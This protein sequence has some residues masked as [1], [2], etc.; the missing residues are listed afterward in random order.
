M[1]IEA[2]NLVPIEDGRYL[3]DL[4]WV[5]HYQVAITFV[6]TPKAPQPPEVRE[7]ARRRAIELYADG[8]RTFQAVADQLNIERVPPHRALMWTKATVRN[9][10]KNR[11]GS[12][13]TP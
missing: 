10:I 3:V 13:A 9:V 1:R 7:A 2:T 11:R 5:T 8:A 4:A 12:E 6:A